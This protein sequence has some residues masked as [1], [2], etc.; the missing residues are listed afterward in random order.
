MSSADAGARPAWTWQRASKAYGS[1]GNPNQWTVNAGLDSLA[2]E[3]AQ[4]SSDA[5]LPG[6]QAEMVFSIVRLTGAGRRRFEEA[7]GWDKDLRPHLAA[8]A[9]TD[10]V[11]AKLLH[12]GLRATEASQEL[13]LLRVE[14]RG[15]VGLTGPE[16]AEND[17]DEGA[18]GNFIKLCRLDLFSNKNAAAGGSF[19]L[20]KAVYWR[21]SRFQ[22]VLFSSTLRAQDAV[23]GHHRNR[24]FGVNQGTVHRVDDVRYESRGHFGVEREEDTASVWADDATARALH[25]HRDS[26][27]PGTTALIPGF[28]DPDQP[29]AGS[30]QL[31]A[32][33]EASLER[34]FWPLMARGGMRFVLEE[35][36]ADGAVIR[37]VTVDAKK[38]LPRLVSALARFDAGTTDDALSLP[39]D[40]VVRDVP[41]AVPSRR[42]DPQHEGFEHVAKLVIT[43]GESND[44]D[45]DDKVALFRRPGMVVQRIGERIP[46]VAYQAFLAAG[47]GVDP[48][49]DDPEV[50]LPLDRADDY[51]RFAEPPAHDLW[52]P[53]SRTPQ[54]SLGSN[55]RPPFL[56]PLRKLR[57]DI[58]RL[59]REEFGILKEDDDVGP[60]AVLKHLRILNDGA[61]GGA[62]ITKPQA[63]LVLEGED[64]PHVNPH[65]AW[66]VVVQVEVLQRDEGWSFEPAV[67]FMA[68]EGHGQRVGW[69]HLAAVDG[70]VIESGRVVLV[71]RTRGRLQRCRFRGTTAPSSH[72]VPAVESAI[73]VSVW[74][75]GPG[76]GPSDRRSG[77]GSQGATS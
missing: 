44:D 45:A 54:T 32:D 29:A 1:Y 37:A 41:I 68:A 43:L 33:L 28:F 58:V 70:C 23:D 73:E 57:S 17:L 60:D 18:Y 36:S 34:S 62:E 4:N 30:E 27:R 55:Y 66:E 77:L 53:N 74:H 65:G 46:G 12:E 13:V 6:E 39:G 61:G 24:I 21:F 71:P 35:R 75:L 16:F 20:G 25:L 51:L 52:I 48:L 7:I 22:T 72:P 42:S 11:V 31:M 38:R 76:P 50:R 9:G 47:A 67:V 8:M 63:H 2:R 64:R 14:D 69:S 5:R 10:Q 56:P 15:C 40:V 49:G 19:G 26:D 3:S 59:L